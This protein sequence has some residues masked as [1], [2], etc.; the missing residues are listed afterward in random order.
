MA[1][2][3]ELIGGPIAA[4]V[5]QFSNRYDW[6]LR[7]TTHINFDTGIVKTVDWRAVAQRIGCDTAN[8]DSDAERVG[9]DA[10]AQIAI[11]RYMAAHPEFTRADLKAVIEET[12]GLEVLSD[13]KFWAIS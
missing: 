5:G 7:M 2:P 12:P 6:S 4:S 8:I 9:V 11:H 1:H 3:Q 13:G 10:A